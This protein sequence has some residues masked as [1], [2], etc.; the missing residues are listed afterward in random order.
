MARFPIREAEI[1]ALAQNMV[2]GLTG[3]EY[4]PPLFPAPPVLPAALQTLLDSVITL[5]DAQ[6]AALATAEQA[7]QAKTA[8]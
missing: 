7:T 6:V 1:K 8:A 4:L 2:T 5:G 3:Q